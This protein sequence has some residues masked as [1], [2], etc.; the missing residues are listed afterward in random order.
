[1]HISTSIWAI[2]KLPSNYKEQLIRLKQAGFTGIDLDLSDAWYRPKFW[3]GEI[4]PE[5]NV[6]LSSTEDAIAYYKPY[7][8]E[9]KKAG[10]EI[11]Q[12]H[13]PF[14]P[15]VPDRPYTIDFAVKSIQGCVKFCVAMGIK[16][17][18]VHGHSLF[19]WDNGHTYQDIQK[20]NEDLYTSLIPMLKGSN[21]IVCLENMFTPYNQTNIRG[22]VGFAIETAKEID[23]YNSLC[24]GEEH[25]GYC[26]D[27]G[28]MNIVHTDMEKF[29]KTL[30]KRIKCTH[31]NDNY[32]G[33][34]DTH[35]LPY[36]GRTDHRPM[37]EGFKSIGY[38]GPIN[39]ETLTW[40]KNAIEVTEALIEFLGATGKYF[41][42]A[43]KG[44][45][46]IWYK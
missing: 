14:P 34:H 22:H 23:Y 32:G 11:A 18:V 9:I 17:V 39:F 5:T 43:I 35:T 19:S 3:V 1:M 44:E 21:T 7:I 10:L 24:D 27:T 42:K 38:D 41:E 33:A 13:A 36:F 2:N 46:E 31:I 30:G 20:M 15:G 25:F 37:L 12:A 29:I 8:D 4:F 40:S 16:Y 28:H 45:V 6:F 26:I